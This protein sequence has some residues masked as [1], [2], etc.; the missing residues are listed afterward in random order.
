M[1]SIDYSPVIKWTFRQSDRSGIEIQ[2]SDLVTD[3]SSISR[4]AVRICGPMQ[5]WVRESQ[6]LTSSLSSVTHMWYGL[7]PTL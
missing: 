2:A 1:L 3:K 6:E 5:A 7:G 4:K